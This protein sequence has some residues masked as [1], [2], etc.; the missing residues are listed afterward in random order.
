M[1]VSVR[2]MDE[3]NHQLFL[4]NPLSRWA[5]ATTVTVAV[6]GTLLVV[7][8]IAVGRIASFAEKTANRADDLLVQVLEGTR[9]A[10]LV[11]ASLAIGARTLDLPDP[12]DLWLG[13]AVIAVFALQGGLWVSHAGRLWT[14]LRAQDARPGAA[15]AARAIAFVTRLVAWS[16][17]VLLV[18]SNF[19]V[20]VTTLIAGLGIGGVAAALAVQ[21]VLGDLFAALS[22]YVDRPFDIGDLVVI[23]SFMGTVERIGWRSTHL[24]SLTGEQIVLA[25]S[26]LARARIRNYKR[27]KARRVVVTFGVEYSTPTE[28]LRRIPVLI[29]EVIEKIDKLRFDRSH[30]VRFGESAL[31]FETVYYVEDPDYRAHVDRLEQVL[32][33]IH[34]R[35]AEEQIRFAFPTR[36]VVVSPDVPASAAAAGAD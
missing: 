20:E 17:V 33:A 23:D 25:N 30:F 2:S 14:E 21:N 36:T 16:L 12:V 4:G 3:M 34:E 32:L 15:T 19:G 7:K 18:L 27:M 26:D 6:F 8:R 29:R 11:A 28:K 24:T 9:T 13:R 10:S 31:E 35:F 22:I 1:R 5:I